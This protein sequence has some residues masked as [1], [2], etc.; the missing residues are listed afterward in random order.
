MKHITFFILFTS[1]CFSVSAQTISKEQAIERARDFFNRSGST[2]R[3]AQLRGGE[4]KAEALEAIASTQILPPDSVPVDVKGNQLEAFYVIRS[5]QSQDGG[6]VVVS[7][8]QR[9][10]P[11]LGYSNH[12]QFDAEEMPCALRAWLTHYATELREAS[13]TEHTYAA[14]ASAARLPVQTGGVEPLIKTSWGQRYPYNKLCPNPNNRSE[15]CLTGC[16]ATALAQILYYYQYP[17]QGKGTYSYKSYIWNT[18]FSVDF[19]NAGPYDWDNMLL[20]YSKS[21]YTEQQADAVATLMYHCGVL[22]KMIYNY[23]ESGSSMTSLDRN[24]IKH[25]GIDGDLYVSSNSSSW[26][27]WHEHILFELNH[28]RPV[29]Y[30]ASEHCFILDGYKTFENN[31]TPYYH[32]N[33]GWNGMY[34]DDYYLLT[35]LPNLTQR[36]PSSHQAY[37]GLHPDDGIDI[38]HLFIRPRVPD[39]WGIGWTIEEPT[40]NIKH[41]Q[42]ATQK[43]KYTINL[44]SSIC[45]REDKTE[46][47]PGIL[48]AVAVD[49]DGKETLLHEFELDNTNQ[50]NITEIETQSKIA[51]L[52]PGRY[53]IEWRNYAP[54]NNEIYT[55]CFSSYTDCFVIYDQDPKLTVV[56]AD[57][58]DIIDAIDNKITATIRNDGTE[59]YY[60]TVKMRLTN[61]KGVS[62]DIFSSYITIA[63]GQECTV[64]FSAQIL[65]L[66]GGPADVTLHNSNNDDPITDTRGDIATFSVDTRPIWPH[67]AFWALQPRSNGYSETGIFFGW[68]INTGKYSYG[69]KNSKAVV[70]DEDDNVIY[71]FP[72]NNSYLEK[73]SLDA[74]SGNTT[75]GN[76]Y[77][78]WFTSVNGDLP[79][80][81]YQVRLGVQQPNS[82]AWTL[83]RPDWK[84]YDMYLTMKLSD[85]EAL[86]GTDEMGWTKFS[87]TKWA[88]KI[89]YSH[90][91]ITVTGQGSA[92]FDY[93]PLHHGH[94]RRTVFKGETGRLRFDCP[95]GYHVSIMLDDNTD[96]TDKVSNQRYDLSNVQADHKLSIAFVQDCGNVNLSSSTT[97]S[98]ADLSTLI[99]IKE[100]KSPMSFCYD[101]ADLNKNGRIDDQDIA[102]LTDM[103]LHNH[104]YEEALKAVDVVLENGHPYVD[105][106]LKSFP[107][108]RWATCNLG[109]ET[110][111]KAG[112]YYAWGEPYEK[113]EYHAGNYLWMEGGDK[114]KV[115]KYNADDGLT[116]VTAA[117]DP[118]R[119]LWGGRWR[120]P[121]EEEMQALAEECDL[122][123]IDSNKY[124]KYNQTIG[125]EYISAN[126]NILFLPEVSY[127]SSDIF[128]I[129]NSYGYYWTASL[130]SSDPSRARIMSLNG[131]MKMSKRS[132]TRCSGLN[133]RPVFDAK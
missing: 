44:V 124:E 66:V 125:H 55:L 32:M 100:G 81:E 129:I 18:D 69:Y 99:A 30:A 109:S 2:M 111:A 126:G 88:G 31:D 115:T 116:R 34:S 113:D 61:E 40:Y 12:T 82:G 70:V 131:N 110:A 9:M 68:E 5:T 58:P 107:N 103:M 65:D 28:R 92:T 112:G 108:L 1:L 119:Q 29:M 122:N 72:N 74:L 11:I 7:A 51:Q 123:F 84:Y 130:D 36:P 78:M 86:I 8:D 26:H 91:D 33:M 106:G 21:T 47:Q 67:V 35:G 22:S 38:P 6:Y 17:K 98:I 80:G 15:P 13:Q 45:E 48:R 89:K 133:I 23:S 120:M 128:F 43:I 50:Y 85:N 94:N 127:R 16:V 79:N 39:T 20:D 102:L 83:Y 73:K 46:P 118:A 56:S 57:I 53:N 95:E 42:T 59:T 10:T 24:C 62:N 75:G 105:M 93:R 101:N 77:G 60:N 54:G 97:P 71:V 3:N 64:D 27:R 52:P 90:V 41:N 49:Q 63:P 37:L 19:D 104:S 132:I 114:E 25:L 76:G 87:R 14:N 121:T 117:D 96:V 4:M